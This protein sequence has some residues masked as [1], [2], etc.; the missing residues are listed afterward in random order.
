MGTTVENSAL[1]EFMHTTRHSHPSHPSHPRGIAVIPQASHSHPIVIPQASQSSQACNYPTVIPQASHSHPTGIPQSSHRH[2]TGV[3]QF[4]SIIPQPA[5]WSLIKVS[6]VS[7]NPKRC[8]ST[9]RHSKENKECKNDLHHRLQQHLL[10]LISMES[11]LR[12]R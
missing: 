3:P 10:Q 8:P 12:D 4:P 1:E 9:G 5:L 7:P 2:P 6:L 11:N